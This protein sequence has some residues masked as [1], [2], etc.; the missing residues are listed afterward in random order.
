[1]LVKKDETLSFSVKI[2]R[3]LHDALDKIRADAKSVDALY[4]PGP[5]VIR[6]LRK[7]IASTEKAIRA[8]RLTN[9]SKFPAE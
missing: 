1:M 2:P 8:V 7:D 9:A 6:A 4:D 3:D 5:A